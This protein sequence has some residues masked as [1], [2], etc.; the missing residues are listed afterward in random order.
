MDTVLENPY[1]PI[2]PSPKQAEFLV[3][4]ATCILYG[5][6]AGGG[7]SAGLLMAGLMYVEVP[8]YNAIILRRSYQ[9]LSLPSALMDMSRDWLVNTDAH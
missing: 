9:D 1:I 5:G 6:G 7:K 4:P 2:I 8:G 3:N